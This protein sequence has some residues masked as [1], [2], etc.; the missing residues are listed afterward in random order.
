LLLAAS[1]FSAFS[2]LLLAASLFSAVS[3]L[4]ASSSSLLLVVAS[5]GTTTV[6]VSFDVSEAYPALHV[7]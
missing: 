4:L 3:P 5:Y 2:A 1:L 7:N 6:F